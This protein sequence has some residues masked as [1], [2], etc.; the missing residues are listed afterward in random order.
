MEWESVPSTG[1]GTVHS[2]VVL[3]HPP[4]PGYEMPI[5]IV[6]VDLEEG[7]RIV[8]NIEGIRPDEVEIGMKVQCSIEEV[9]EDW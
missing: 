6:L 2:Y 5:P 3:H 4:M 1:Q 8:S 9:E 7:T